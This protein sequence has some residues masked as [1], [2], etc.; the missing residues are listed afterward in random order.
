MT[1]SDGTRLALA[2]LAAWLLGCVIAAALY[3]LVR[4]VS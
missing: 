3:V 1:M 4:A 2:A